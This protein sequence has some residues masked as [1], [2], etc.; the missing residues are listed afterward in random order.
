VLSAP[1]HMGLDDSLEYLAAD[2]LIEVGCAHHLL[3][4]CR[5]FLCCR[6]FIRDLTRSNTVTGD[7]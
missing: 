5:C 4:C 7:S 6:A 1:I 2:E 3:M